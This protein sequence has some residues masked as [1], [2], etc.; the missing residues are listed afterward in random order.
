MSIANELIV[1][2]WRSGEIQDN[3]G[4]V[5]LLG[6]AAHASGLANQ[7]LGVRLDEIA[8]WYLELHAP[9]YLDALYIAIGAPAID[10]ENSDLCDAVWRFN[11]REGTEESA[12]RVAK[13]AD[14]ILDGLR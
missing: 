3:E 10:L 4:R 5:C 1:R 14:E 13:E 6:A 2:G 12:L 8:Y 11:D 7:I 9:Q